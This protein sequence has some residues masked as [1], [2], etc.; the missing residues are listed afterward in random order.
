[1]PSSDRLATPEQ[2]PTRRARG[3]HVLAAVFMAVCAAVALLICAAAAAT[4]AWLVVAFA[5]LLS[6]FFLLVL[7]H[8]AL[9]W[10]F[11]QHTERDVTLGEYRGSQALALRTSGPLFTVLVALVTCLTLLFGLA[12]VQTLRLGGGSGLL[13]GVLFG[14][15][16]V[17]FGSFLVAVLSGRVARGV[18]ALTPSGIYQRGRAFESFLPWEIIVGA[19][20]AYDGTSPQVLV[21]A[22]PDAT[23]ERRKAT[24]VWRLDHLPPV[25]MIAVDCLTFAIDQNL[26]HRLVTYYVDHP[27][28]RDEL[29]TQAALSRVASLR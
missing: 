4:G 7:A 6:G 28:A 27:Q 8:G 2:W 16:T 9:V 24:R 14:A 23:W 22:S 20:A 21:V 29:G 10:L 12:T 19:K 26:I 3:R 18:L 17:F 13:G 15:A 25:P 5:A 11:P 1:M